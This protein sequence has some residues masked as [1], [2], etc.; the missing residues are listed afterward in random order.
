MLPSLASVIPKI[1]ASPDLIISGGVEG[2]DN[3]FEL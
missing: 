1:R 3:D 2:S